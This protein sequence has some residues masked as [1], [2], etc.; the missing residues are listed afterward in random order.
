MTLASCTWEQAASD[1]LQEVPRAKIFKTIITIQLPVQLT[2]PHL[3]TSD[4]HTQAGN[5]NSK[6]INN[7]P[8]AILT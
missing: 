5:L 8:L 3:P 6:S 2:N 4:F 1:L 7:Y